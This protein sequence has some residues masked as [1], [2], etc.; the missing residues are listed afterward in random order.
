MNMHDM[1]ATATCPNCNRPIPIKVREMVP[2]T[3]R[4]CPHGCGATLTFSGDDGRKAQSALDDLERAFR[5][6]GGR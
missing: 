6:L 4:S 5:R 3:S 1:E 2:G